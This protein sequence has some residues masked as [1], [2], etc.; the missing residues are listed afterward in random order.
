MPTLLFS[1]KGVAE[2]YTVPEPAV[3]VS[4]CVSECVCVCVCVCARARAK[5]RESVFPSSMALSAKF[6]LANLWG[7]K[8]SCISSLRTHSLVF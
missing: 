2:G 1:M 5:E 6:L 8:V 4:V 7:V 3:R